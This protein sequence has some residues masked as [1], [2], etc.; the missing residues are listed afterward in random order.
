MKTWT[1]I[2]GG[3]KA[4]ALETCSRRP[5]PV[6]QSL[7]QTQCETIIPGPD[8]HGVSASPH[9]VRIQSPTK[10]AIRRWDD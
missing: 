3:R 7:N 4:W 9:C 8:D 2:V 10:M 5:E 6:N 1:E